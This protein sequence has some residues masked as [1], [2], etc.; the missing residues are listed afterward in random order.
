MES[1]HGPCGPHGLANRF[2]KPPRHSPKS[3]PL[4]VYLGGWRKNRTPRDLTLARVRAGARHQPRIAIQGFCEFQK[5]VTVASSGCAPTYEVM[6]N[7]FLEGTQEL[8]LTLQPHCILNADIIPATIH[9]NYEWVSPFARPATIDGVRRDDIAPSIEHSRHRVGLLGV[10]E[11][12]Q[13]R[14]PG[15][16]GLPGFKSGRSTGYV[17]PSRWR[18]A[19]ESNTM[20]SSPTNPLPT[21]AGPRPVNHPFGA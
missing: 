21:G 5:K 13:S 14:T 10:A 4:Q 11:G 8:R 15:P 6:T 18:M 1:N 2:E 9:A 17:S 3:N 19:G 20:E 16:R 7:Q 12:G